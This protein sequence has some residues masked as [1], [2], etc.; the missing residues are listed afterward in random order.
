[1]ADVV[2][3]DGLPDGL[4]SDVRAGELDGL[5]LELDDLLLEQPTATTVT[6]VAPATATI[7][8]RIRRRP[9]YVS[10]DSHQYY[11]G[12]ARASTNHGIASQTA[13]VASCAQW[14]IHLRSE[15]VR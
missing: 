14:M 12:D 10:N 7:N 9:S 2:G 15:A 13:T 5:V 4:A 3:S 1:L 11:R 8:P 6:I